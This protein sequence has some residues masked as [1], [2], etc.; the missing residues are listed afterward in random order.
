M[1]PINK[2]LVSKK[3]ILIQSHTFQLVLAMSNSAVSSVNFSNYFIHFFQVKTFL[4]KE[5]QQVALSYWLAAF[6]PPGWAKTTFS[7][8]EIKIM[9]STNCFQ[10]F[11]VCFFRV[12]PSSSREFSFCS[13]S[14]I[15][16]TRPVD[17][18]LGII[19]TFHLQKKT[20]IF[21]LDCMT[22]GHSHVVCAA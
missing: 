22:V 4:S 3:I 9:Y 10:A 6:C 5:T 20:P 16:F 8:I 18:V 12:L 11:Y 21:F 15:F 17:F 14:T 1:A 13:L 7:Y 19:S 2:S